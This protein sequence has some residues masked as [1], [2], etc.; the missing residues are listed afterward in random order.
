MNEDEKRMIVKSLNEVP[1][2]IKLSS[3]RILGLSNQALAKENILEGLSYEIKRE[4]ARETNQ[5]NKKVFPNQDMRDSEFVL[6]SGSNGDY[7]NLKKE[8][9]NLQHESAKEKIYLEYL[10]NKFSASRSIARLF[11]GE[12]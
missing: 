2:E 1:T 7:V 11:S 5:E 6:R 10:K 3:L 9:G 4:I 8:I 12:E